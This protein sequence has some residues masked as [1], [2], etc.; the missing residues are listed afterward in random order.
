MAPIFDH[1]VMQLYRTCEENGKK[2]TISASIGIASVPEHGTCFE[3]LYF[4][5]DHA[6]YQVKETQKNGWKAQP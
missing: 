6:L 1:L 2:V 5:A 4:Q 3:Q